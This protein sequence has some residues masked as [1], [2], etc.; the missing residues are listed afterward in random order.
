MSLSHSLHLPSKL[1]C[2]RATTKYMGRY[3]PSG[4]LRQRAAG[5]RDSDQEPPRMHKSCS[6]F[7]PVSKPIVMPTNAPYFDAQCEPF[8]SQQSVVGQS[9][10]D[11]E[12]PRMPMSSSVFDPV[13]RPIAVPTTTAY[14][15]D[16]FPAKNDLSFRG[17]FDV[18]GDDRK[19]KAIRVLSVPHFEV[20]MPSKPWVDS[21]YMNRVRIDVKSI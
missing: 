11:Q 17:R 13:T 8:T 16:Q 3:H 7:D 1:S 5:Q 20:N 19:L 14:F 4:K 18:G 6:V 21:N 10:S 15:Y 12:L 9:S 2:F